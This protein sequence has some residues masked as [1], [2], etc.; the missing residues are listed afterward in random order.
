MSNEKRF[1]HLEICIKEIQ[2]YVIFTTQKYVPGKA[3]EEGVDYVPDLAAQRAEINQI[4][5]FVPL[6][7]FISIKKFGLL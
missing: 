6:Y 7:R 5:A 4:K 3:E 2:K 1:A